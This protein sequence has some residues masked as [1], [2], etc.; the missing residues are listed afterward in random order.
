MFDV[1]TYEKGA[2]VVRMLEQ[3]LGEDAFREGIRLYIAR[4]AHGNTETTD[5]WDA[6]E[7]ATGEPVRRI[8]DSWI[9][10]GGYP[11]VSRRRAPTATTA[12]CWPSPV[13]VP[14]RHR[15]EGDDDARWAVPGAG[16][17]VAWGPPTATRRPSSGQRT[18]RVLLEE[19]RPRSTWAPDPAGC[20]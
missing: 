4:H 11:V 5:L 6:I 9:F 7:E 17:L 3:Y 8:M 1:L 2:A 19:R 12:P 18:E 16:A 20:W 13:P 15:R 10:Q 14:L